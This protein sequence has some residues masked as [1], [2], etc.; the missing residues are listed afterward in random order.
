MDHYGI[1][2]REHYGID[3]EWDY[4]YEGSEFNVYKPV[5]EAPG[6]NLIRNLSQFIAELRD[7][8]AAIPSASNRPTNTTSSRWQKTQRGTR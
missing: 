3:V 4:C 8:V 2:I 5:R 7:R 1:Y 6:G